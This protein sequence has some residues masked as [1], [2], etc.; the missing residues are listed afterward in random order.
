VPSGERARGPAILCY[1]GS[2]GARRALRE[3][4]R[5]LGG[6]PAVVLTVWESLSSALLRPKPLESTELGRELKE[7]SE[8]VA[9]ELDAGIADQARVTALEGVEVAR[10]AGFQAEPEARRAIARTAERDAVTVWRAIRDAADE[11]GAG[12]IVLGSRGRSG[13][14]S[15]VLGSV[16]YGVVHNSTRPVLIVPPGIR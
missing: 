7:I 3:S 11:K 16:S 4:S 10:D 2:E 9:Q 5:L 6:G 13:F 14:E 12:A 1:D 15:V 8:D